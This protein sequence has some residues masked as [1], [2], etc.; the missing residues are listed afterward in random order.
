MFYDFNLWLV[1]WLFFEVVWREILNIWNEVDIIKVL[2]EEVKFLIN[3]GDD[4][5]DEVVFGILWYDKLKFLLVIDGFEGCWYYIFMFK[6][7]V[8]FFKVVVIDIMG[9]GD[10]FVVGLL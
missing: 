3:G 5:L 1:F 8:D 4:K 6:G 7:Y 2:D 10:V 9:V